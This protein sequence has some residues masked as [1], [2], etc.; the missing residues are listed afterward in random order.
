M[1]SINS[2]A[3]GVFFFKNGKSL[4]DLN[5]KK[6]KSEELV[7][8]QNKNQHWYITFKD[9]WKIIEQKV[10]KIQSESYGKTLNNLLKYIQDVN[11]NDPNLQ[12]AVLLTGVNQTDH[13][14]QFDSLSTKIYNNCYSIVTILKS[15]DCPNI[16]SAIE[17]LVHGL[18]YNTSKN[19]EDD[20]NEDESINVKLKKKQLTLSVL[21]AWFNG[22]Y[23]TSKKKPKLVIM[24]ADFE[25]FNP[26]VMQELI[27][28]LCAY[29]FRL[30]LI[31]IL[32]IATAFKTLHNVLPFHIT[33]KITAN[34]FQAQSAT[35]M[36][37]QIL[38]EII[39]TH[40][41]PFFLSGKSFNVL[42]DIFLFYDYSLHSFIQGFKIFML[43]QFMTNSFSSIYSPEGKMYD[44]VIDSLTHEECENIRKSCMSFRKFVEEQEDPQVRID[45]IKNDDELKK[46]IIK[47]KLR[48]YRYFYKFFICLRMLSILIEDL[49]RNNLGTLLRELYP[50]CANEEIIKNE[51]FKEC[52]KYLRFTSK[53]QFINKLDKVIK[54]LDIS[55]TDN[56]LNNLAKSKFI[57]TLEKLQSHREKIFNAGMAPVKV[58]TPQKSVEVTGEKA[59]SRLQMME[60]LKESAMNNAP[61]T[62][63]EYEK[64]LIECLD[65][66]HNVFEKNLVPFN[67][68][69]ALVE[70]FIFS[71][72][73]SIRRQ[74][75]GA[76]R[77]AIH[78]ALSNPHHYLQ[79]SCC[80]LKDNEQI[81]PSM[82]DICIAYKLHLECNKFINLYD[83]LQAFSMVVDNNEDEE[84]I[85]PEVQ[86]RFTR[87]TAEL[88]FLGLIKQAKQKTD[89]VM[90]LTW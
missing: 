64:C 18:I 16:K 27:G 32:G 49:P 10:E 59:M 77:G 90:R 56:T 22:N 67:K 44:G 38:D 50:V 82:P 89:H 35:S 5:K 12:T 45:L 3:K 78:N 66:L 55:L 80:E 26:V 61:R 69:P 41:C 6:R 25:Q 88:Q 87:A 79:C 29:T 42:V 34:V 36:L 4:K 74:I 31:L 51:D 86:A 63:I 39:L 70:L 37:N 60:K 57:K 47:Q 58:D 46:L 85:K 48:I 30:P 54:I 33:S 1:D 7:N 8:K 81:L 11:L 19:N 23:K 43:E 72:Y 21:E 73:S 65:Y 53:D 76:P 52:F 17:T 13:F 40:Q 62:V 71:D 14:K 28:I 75:V 84:S 15:R 83:W 20:E 9:E 2:V 24:L 68:G